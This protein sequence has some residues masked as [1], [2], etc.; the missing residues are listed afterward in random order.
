MRFVKAGVLS[1]KDVQDQLNNNFSVVIVDV[2]EQPNIAAKYQVMGT[3]TCVILDSNGKVISKMEGYRTSDE[4]L[5]EIKE[6]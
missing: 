2:N 1:N 5:N 4:V 3:P 6:I